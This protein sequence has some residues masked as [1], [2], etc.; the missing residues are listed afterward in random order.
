MSQREDKLRALI[1]VLKLTKEDEIDCDE[2]WER[3]SWLAEQS[4]SLD[5]ES[6][7]SYLHHL[8]LCPDCAEEFKFL[9]ECVEKDET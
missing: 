6:L 4:V 1:E 7:A 9:N 5:L 8:N 2:F 3:A